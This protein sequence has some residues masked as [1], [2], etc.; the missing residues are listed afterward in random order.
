MVFSRVDAMRSIFPKTTS[1]QGRSSQA[2]GFKKTS[3][4]V[5]EESEDALFRH[6][7]GDVGV[8]YHKIFSGAAILQT[9]LRSIELSDQVRGLVVPSMNMKRQP[10]QCR[11]KRKGK[12]ERNKS[13]VSEKRS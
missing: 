8:S 13:P 2:G 3:V 7:L 1:F 11:K 6:R 12:K 10:S 5:S 9:S 4:L